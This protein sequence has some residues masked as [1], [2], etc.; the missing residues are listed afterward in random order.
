MAPL[1]FIPIEQIALRKLE[2]IQI[3][4]FDEWNTNAIECSE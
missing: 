4:L 2:F 1:N 3:V